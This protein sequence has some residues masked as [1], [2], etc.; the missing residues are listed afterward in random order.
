MLEYVSRVCAVLFYDKFGIDLVCVLLFSLF[1]DGGG[2]ILV[3]GRALD[4]YCAARSV[5]RREAIP[6]LGGKL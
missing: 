5:V 4:L 6:K 1:P 3:M 2:W